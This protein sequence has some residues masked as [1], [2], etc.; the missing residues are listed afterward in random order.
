MREKRNA[1]EMVGTNKIVVDRIKVQNNAEMNDKMK[2]KFIHEKK[3]GKM[4]ELSRKIEITN[5]KIEM[6]ENDAERQSMQDKLRA[7]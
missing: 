2:D 7:L 1:Y 4:K 6:S 3:E 5:I